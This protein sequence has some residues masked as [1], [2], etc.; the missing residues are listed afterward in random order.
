MDLLKTRF[1]ELMVEAN[2]FDSND[3]AH[4]LFCPGM[5]FNSPDKWWGDYGQ[6]DFPHE[7]LDFCLY[8]RRS[9]KIMRVDPDTRI[10]V[11]QDGVVRAMFA[12][13]LGQALIVEHVGA[14]NG[15]R[16]WLSVYAHTKPLEAIEPGL[17][18]KK[19][20]VIATIA[21][22]SHSK[23]GIFPHLHVTL[24]L[25]SAHL[26]YD[27]FVWNRMRDP[28]LVALLDPLAIIEGHYQVLD[29]QD[30]YCTAIN[31]SDGI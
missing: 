31:P 22:T 28:G 15:N 29:P 4:W 11:M 1:S 12:D 2:S 23:A 5:L 20:T 10:P 13:Y 27:R 17:F 24:G 19:G 14:H 26:S 18:V 25:P 7:G 21:D 9:A 8:E 6:R 30:R 16:R 3:F